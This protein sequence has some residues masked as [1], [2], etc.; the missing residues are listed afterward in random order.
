MFECLVFEYVKPRYGS[1]HLVVC[2]FWVQSAVPF[3]YLQVILRRPASLGL[4]FRYLASHFRVSILVR[5]IKV[6]DDLYS[7]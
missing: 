5:I 6:S 1:N 4:L 3:L 2:D 7:S